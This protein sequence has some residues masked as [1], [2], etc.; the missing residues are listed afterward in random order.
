ML[1]EFFSISLSASKAFVRFVMQES[2]DQILEFLG[3]ACY[4]GEVN[5][6]GGDC[7]QKLHLVLVLERWTTTVHLIEKSTKTPPINGLAMTFPFDDFGRKI[8][9]CPTDCKSHIFILLKDTLL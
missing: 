9:R 7:V 3:S 5:A 8:L 6:L 2:L 1:L 4:P